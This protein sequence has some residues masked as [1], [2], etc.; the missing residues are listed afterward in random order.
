MLLEPL[1]TTLDVRKA[2][3]RGAI[4]TGILKPTDLARFLPLVAGPEGTI[5][6]KMEF[7]RDEEGRYLLHLSIEADLLVTCQR[8]LETLPTHIGSDCVLAVVWTDEEAAHL[9]KHLEPLI[10]KESLCSLWPIVEDELILSLPA[11]SYHE[12]EDCKL[13]IAEFSDPTPQEVT[14]DEKPNPFNLLGQ[15]KPGK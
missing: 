4:V 13:S 9:P 11:Y 3:A 1:P 10:V 14:G 15:L 5:L 6:V 8:C 7:S 12:A 2:A